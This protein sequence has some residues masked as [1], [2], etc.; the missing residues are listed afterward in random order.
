MA[1]WVTGIDFVLTVLIAGA[2]TGTAWF[3]VREM[4]LRPS[5]PDAP[6]AVPGDIG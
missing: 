6:D 3:I 5:I 2:S 1:G 4:S